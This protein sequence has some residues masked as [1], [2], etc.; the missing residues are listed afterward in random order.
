M[1]GKIRLNCNIYAHS[2]SD[3]CLRNFYF[4]DTPKQQQQQKSHHHQHF[5]DKWDP[6]PH[7]VGGIL[8]LIASPLHVAFSEICLQRISLQ[9]RGSR[10]QGGDCTWVK[11]KR[12]I[13]GKRVT[14][15]PFVA[16]KVRLWEIGCLLL[17]CL[18]SGFVSQLHSLTQLCVPRNSTYLVTKSLHLGNK[19]VGAF[20]V[21]VE[22]CKGF[23]VVGCFLMLNSLF[24][25]LAND[26]VRR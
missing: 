9:T 6:L 10:G 12:C 24:T 8:D 15:V 3:E 2:L 22:G 1:G 26:S 16:L 7:P 5:W 11:L 23:E 19:A 25:K 21:I 18:K 17:L 4:P 13:P 14:V 20:E